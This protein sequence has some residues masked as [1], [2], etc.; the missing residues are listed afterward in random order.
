[1]LLIG[2]EVIATTMRAEVAAVWNGKNFKCL[3]LRLADIFN[4]WCGVP[5]AG[6]IRLGSSDAQGRWLVF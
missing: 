2:V 1:M 6:D 5:R 4:V 3:M